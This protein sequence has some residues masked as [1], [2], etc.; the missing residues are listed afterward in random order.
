M[1]KFKSYQDYMEYSYLTDIDDLEEGDVVVVD[2]WVDVPLVVFM[3]LLTPDF[4]F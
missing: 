2:V 1:I 3:L 4:W